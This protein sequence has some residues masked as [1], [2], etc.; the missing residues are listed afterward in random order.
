MR[1]G[2]RAGGG[3]VGTVCLF[4]GRA[5]C[6]ERYFEVVNDLRRRGFA[7]ATIDWRGQGGSDRRAAQ[8][9]RR[10]TSTASTNMTAT[11]T[12]SC[13]RWCC[14]TA[15]RPISP[16]RIRPAGWSACAPPVPA[17]HAS[18]AWCWRR[19]WS[20]SA[21]NGRRQG[22]ILA[23]TALMTA[24]GLGELDLSRSHNHADRRERLRGQSVHDG[25][26]ALCPQ[27][28]R[29]TGNCR[30]FRS[31][32]RP[33]AGCMPPARRWRRRASR[34]SRLA[35]T[36]PDPG[37]GRHAGYRRFG[38]RDRNAGGRTPRRRPGHSC[39]APGTS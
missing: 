10:A 13:S 16:W 24:I 29:S 18:P 20:D 31:A 25:S 32:R 19:R 27:C 36:V 3:R 38:Q 17:A 8:S 7:V 33:M 30:R 6:I 34:I 15:R 39:P 9:D 21:A 5:E 26:A 37:R 28:R 35:I 11:S 23:G 1:G 14:R 2:S 4:Q 22:M 12:A